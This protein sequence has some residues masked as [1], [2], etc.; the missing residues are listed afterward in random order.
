MSSSHENQATRLHHASTYEPDEIDSGGG[1][2]AALVTA[3][4]GK[5]L[6]PGSEM[7]LDE[8]PNEPS[9]DVVDLQRDPPWIAHRETKGRFAAGHVDKSQGCIAQNQIVILA[10]A[11]PGI[12]RWHRSRRNPIEVQT[13]SAG[14]EE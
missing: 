8:L 14:P 5:L 6:F 13:L 12:A 2:L 1:L 11:T 4:P 7:V 3:A 9:A 10:V